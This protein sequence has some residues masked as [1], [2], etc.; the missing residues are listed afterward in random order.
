MS[1][2]RHFYSFARRS[3][4]VAGRHV[5]ST[6]HVSLCE[7]LTHRWCRMSI[8]WCGLQR[9]RERLRRGYC[10]MTLHGWSDAATGYVSATKRWRMV[11]MKKETQATW[12]VAMDYVSVESSGIAN[13]SVHSSPSR[14]RTLDGHCTS[15][16][17]QG[18]WWKTLLRR[19]VE[20][21]TVILYLGNKVFE[22]LLS[23]CNK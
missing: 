7:A 19:S 3:T 22:M 17:H 21:N 5:R 14:I 1:V 15:T 9:D 23:V 11:A 2:W 4:I 8:V 12:P 20:K 13:D 18:D 6:T 16:W 10:H